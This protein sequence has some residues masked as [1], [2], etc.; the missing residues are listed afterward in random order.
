VLTNFAAATVPRTADSFDLSSYVMYAPL[1]QLNFQAKDL[2][3][4]GLPG[5]TTTSSSA[6]PTS[7]SS[8]GSGSSPQST[9]SIASQTSTPAKIT[10]TIPGQTTITQTAA[11]SQIPWGA[12]ADNSSQP[13][14]SGDSG[15]L[16]QGA[17]IGIGVGVGIGGLI[18]ALLALLIILR[19]ARNRRED[20][21]ATVASTEAG[22]YTSASSEKRASPGDPNGAPGAR[23]SAFA[24]APGA[25]PD[26]KV[27]LAAA[28]AG[29]GAGLGGAAAAGKHAQ[30]GNEPISELDGKPFYPEL[31]TRL[32]SDRRP[33]GDPVRWRVSDA[34]WVVS[35]HTDGS[36]TMGGPMPLVDEHGNV[37]T[38]ST[39][40]RPHGNRLFELD[41][42]ERG[43]ERG[44]V[45]GSARGS[46]RG[47]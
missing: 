32:P 10:E 12:G 16:S 31:P 22:D 47:A 35:P 38:P 5:Q 15:G 41:G 24:S 25:G 2:P 46:V 1:Y 26:A 18:A 45:E 42:S 34:D 11:Q 44:S 9:S 13:A 19:L 21:A 6:T 14:S 43:S 27:P 20:K 7:A 36:G 23:A 3:P 30:A 40:T 4:G 33:P 28:A 8:S 37:V 17:K 29:T 39:P